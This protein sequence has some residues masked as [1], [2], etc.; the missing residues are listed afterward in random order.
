M[1][2]AARL[3][4][5]ESFLATILDDSAAKVAINKATIYSYF[6]GKEQLLYKILTR[7]LQ[8]YIGCARANP[9]ILWFKNASPLSAEQVADGTWGFVSRGLRNREGDKTHGE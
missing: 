9:A 4:R 5:E 1:L 3:F 8:G 6:K 7:A 2:V